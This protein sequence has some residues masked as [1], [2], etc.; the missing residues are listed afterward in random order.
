MKN[1]CI[2]LLLLLFLVAN[3]NGQSDKEM[4][5]SIVQ[6]MFDSMRDADTVGLSEIFHP[7]AT[8]MRTF[9]DKNGDPRLSGGGIQSF[10]TG[11]G[12]APKNA[13]DEKIWSY[14]VRIDQNLATVWT[15]FT[16][17]YNGKMSHCGVNTFQLFKSDE[18][19]KI[20]SITDTKRT[21][22][23]ITEQSF[24]ETAVDA[25]LTEWHQAATNAYADTY[26]GLM[27]DD[28]YFIGT[29][30]SER[31]NR[32]E[33]QS[34]AKGAFKEAPA[35]DFKLLER[36]IEMDE[37]KNRVW[38]DEKLDTWMGICRGSGVAVNTPEGWKIKHYVLSVTIPND[39]VRAVKQ[40]I[41]TK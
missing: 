22:G 31:W 33:F 11:V 20:F 17:Y 3:L 10:I 9:N 41:D 21:D 2:S 29:D 19:W 28:S 30:A 38:F 24:A 34:F 25:M 32:S 27:T 26:F 18:G 6:K 35:W 5:I 37:D 40:L 16:F 15:D 8:L 12:K 1:T 14:D 7:D 36:N 4:V 39:K 23:C 13:L